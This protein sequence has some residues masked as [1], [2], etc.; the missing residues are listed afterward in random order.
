MVKIKPLNDYVLVELEKQEPKTSSGIITAPSSKEQPGKGKVLKIW[1]G[2][3]TDDGKLVKIENIKEWD[4][5][6]FTKYSPEE[7]EVDWQKYLL[8]RFDSIIAK[9]E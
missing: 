9:E 8:V 5:V 1:E 2:K 4:V 7:I 6:Y 3:I